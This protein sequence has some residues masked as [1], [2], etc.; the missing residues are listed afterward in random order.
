MF[1]SRIEVIPPVEESCF[2]EVVR[3]IFQHVLIMNLLKNDNDDIDLINLINIIEFRSVIS[4]IAYLVK[5][6]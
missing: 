1:D 2:D 6:I 5:L 3:N 4:S